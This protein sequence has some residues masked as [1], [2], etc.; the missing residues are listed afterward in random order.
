MALLLVLAVVIFFIVASNAV[1]GYRSTGEPTH[2]CADCGSSFGGVVSKRARWSYLA[3]P[4][5]LLL[6]AKKLQPCPAC[7][8]KL[9]PIDSPKGRALAGKSETGSI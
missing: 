5:N 9:I 6:A 1:G 7:D 4:W 2:I 3:W 8:G